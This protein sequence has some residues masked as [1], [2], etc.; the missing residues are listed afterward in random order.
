MFLT[1]T[2]MVTLDSPDRQKAYEGILTKLAGRA[3]LTSIEQI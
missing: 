1:V 3:I 2:G